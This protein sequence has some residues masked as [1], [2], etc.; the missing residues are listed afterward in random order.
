MQNVLQIAVD[1]GYMIK[2]IWLSLSAIAYF[3][4]SHC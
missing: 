1:K 3:D 4:S 2:S